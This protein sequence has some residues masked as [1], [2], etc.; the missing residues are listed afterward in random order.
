M[1][2]VFQPGGQPGVWQNICAETE[3]WDS[4]LIVI[5]L[6]VIITLTLAYQLVLV[7]PKMKYGQSP[8]IPAIYDM[9]FIHIYKE[10]PYFSNSKCALPVTS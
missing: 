2:C 8:K 3:Y 10:M 4:H 5:Y 1:A 9:P 7:L 6:V